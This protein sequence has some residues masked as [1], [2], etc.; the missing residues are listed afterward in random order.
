MCDC[1]RNII[2]N[3][4]QKGYEEVDAPMELLSGR[5]YIE[6]IGRKKGQKKVRK[7]PVVLPKCPF[8]GKNYENTE[9]LQ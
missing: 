1:V 7:I 8:C 3:I 5:L 2:V 4:E 6:F 9:V